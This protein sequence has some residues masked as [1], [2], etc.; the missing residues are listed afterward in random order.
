MGYFPPCYDACADR[1][2]AEIRDFPKSLLAHEYD[3][4]VDVCLR[5][6]ANATNLRSCKWT[7]DGSMS[8]EVLQILLRCAGLEELEINGHHDS[9]VLKRF[10]SLRKISLIMPT[11]SVIGALPRWIRGL[12]NDLRSLTIIC[13]VALFIVF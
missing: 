3:E 13:K 10:E 2:F 9:D 7:R 5:G 1:N 11:P 4:L 8:S 6:I 12:Q